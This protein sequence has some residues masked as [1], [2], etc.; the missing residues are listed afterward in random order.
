MGLGG[1]PR[2]SAGA[3]NPDL[4]RRTSATSLLQVA[5]NPTDVGSELSSYLDSDNVR[6]FDNDFNLLD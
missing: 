1:S 4:L 5:S 6:K 3:S 2:L